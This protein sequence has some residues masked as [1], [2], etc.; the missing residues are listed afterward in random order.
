V[1]HVSRRSVL[2]VQNFVGLNIAALIG[3]IHFHSDLRLTRLL[4]KQLYTKMSQ[5]L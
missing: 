3:Q 1:S 2:P 4:L 5:Q